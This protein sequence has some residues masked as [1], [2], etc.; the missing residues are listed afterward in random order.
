[1][2]IATAGGLVAVVMAM[3]LP[4]GGPAEEECPGGCTESTVNTTS[5]LDAL[6]HD[7]FRAQQSI[8]AAAMVQRRNVRVVNPAPA[9]TETTT[10]P[11]CC[12]TYCPTTADTT[13]TYTADTA[14]NY[15]APPTHTPP[16]TAAFTTPTMTCPGHHCIAANP[17][18]Q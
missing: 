11:T 7:T 8:A 18:S 3:T 14:I 13:T 16:T 4:W 1:M 10:K 2:H 15:T 5:E 6:E 9:P 17:Y 12:C